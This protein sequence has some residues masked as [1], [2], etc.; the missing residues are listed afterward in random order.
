MQHDQTLLCRIR[1]QQ[2]LLTL[3]SMKL[4]PLWLGLSKLL[5]K[6]AIVGWMKDSSAEIADPSQAEQANLTS[7]TAG[8]RHITIKDE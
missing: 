1:V 6:I 7:G 5:G 8:M 4:S 2:F 3:Q